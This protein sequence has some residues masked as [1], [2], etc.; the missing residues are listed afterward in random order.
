MNSSEW[1]ESVEKLAGEFGHEDP[2]AAGCRVRSYEKVGAID[3]NRLGA[4]QGTAP[5]SDRRVD[6]AN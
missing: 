6:S 2:V 5:T 1:Q 4:L 3:L